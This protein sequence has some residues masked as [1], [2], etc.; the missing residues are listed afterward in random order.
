[1]TAGRRSCSGSWV[2]YPHGSAFR[3]DF[4]YYGL[5]PG[6]YDLKRL[7]QP[8]GWLVRQATCRRFPC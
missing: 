8:Q 2:S 5:E 1:M 4:V 3:Y 7:A 6:T